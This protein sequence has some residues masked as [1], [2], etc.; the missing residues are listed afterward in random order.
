MA[1]SLPKGKQVLVTGASSGIG[2][3][4]ALAFARCGA[5]LILVDINATALDTA[6]CAEG[7][8]GPAC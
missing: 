3:E 2:Y 7:V 1:V 8:A 5:N 4:T 6:A